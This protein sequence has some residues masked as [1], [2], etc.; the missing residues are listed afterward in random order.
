MDVLL[1]AAGLGTRLRPI[2]NTIPK[3][4]VEIEGKPL[5]QWWLEALDEIQVERIFI[6]THYLHKQVEAFVE[7][8]AFAD[9]VVLLYEPQLK[10][11][12]G[13]LKS[14]STLLHSNEL[15]VIHADNFCQANW[16]EF[17]RAHKQRAAECHTTM[18]LF[19]TP[20]PRSC[21]IVTV[22]ERR[23]LNSYVE[24]PDTDEFGN[25]ANAA[26]FIFDTVAL[27]MLKQFNQQKTDL[28]ADFIPTQV[29]KIQTY[30]NQGTLIDIGT[31]EKLDH[32]RVIASQQ[33][34]QDH[35][36]TSENM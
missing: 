19:R 31:P 4:L 21:G 13:T 8:S 32:A 34:H 5:L 6:N 12:L 14:H 25:L 10:G 9:R 30:L 3:C 36:I 28:C 26:I 20:E 11:T 33:I 2:T 27:T 22:D 23:V 24:K 29:G 7:Q 35:T 16:S 17:I 1:L 15:L 18:M